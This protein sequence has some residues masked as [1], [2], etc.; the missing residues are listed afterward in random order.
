M[1]NNK[2]KQLRKMFKELRKRAVMK[3]I[4]ARPFQQ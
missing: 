1:S 2:A 4:E 3:R